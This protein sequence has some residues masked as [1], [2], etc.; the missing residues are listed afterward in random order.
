M[1]DESADPCFDKSGAK[2]NDVPQSH[3]N[4]RFNAML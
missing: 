3:A 4:R 2:A 1:A